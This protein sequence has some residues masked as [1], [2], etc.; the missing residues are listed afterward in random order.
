MAAIYKITNLVNNKIYIGQTIN[1]IDKRF[2]QHLSQVNCANICSA[3]YSA[4]TKY[5]KENFIIESIVSGEYSREEL[6][7]LEIFY[8]KKFDSLSPNGYNLQSG[9]N[10]FM[11]VESVKKQTSEK[12]KGREITWKAKVSEGL[13]KIWLNKEY[14]EKQ[15]LQRHEKRGKYREGIQKPLRINLNVELINKMYANGDTVYK[16]AKYFNVSFYTIKKR[17]RNENR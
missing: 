6:N 11:V 4:F 14:R 17:I 7:E 15:T 1:S 10:S 12:L 16:I 13:K 5:G 8:I 9:G 3:L 2:K